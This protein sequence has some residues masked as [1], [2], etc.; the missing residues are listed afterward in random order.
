MLV[1]QDLCSG[2]AGS[3]VLHNLS[4][5]IS[6]EKIILL[7]GPNGA[8][9]STLLETMLGLIRATSGHVSYNDQD[10]TNHHAAD[11]IR[12]GISYS[13]QG[14]R[15]FPTMSVRENLEMGGYL[16]KSKGD[17]QKRIKEIQEIFPL[18]R[19][20]IDQKAGFMSGGERQLLVIARSL[21]SMP[22]LIMLDEPSAGLDIGKQKLIFE[23]L[24]E[25]NKR[26]IGILLVEQNIKEAS[27]I[28]DYVYFMSSGQVKFEGK[29]DEFAKESSIT[30]G[31]FHK[32]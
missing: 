21:I 18:L 19:E 20:R 28:S 10:I 4:L 16:L 3:E 22:R 2:Y 9:K 17:V 26:K 5:K 32:V 25:V 27:L 13:P 7:T 8:G 23:R 24:R 31:M 15:I 30:A 29:P 1:V 6:D 11:I 14:A 12:K